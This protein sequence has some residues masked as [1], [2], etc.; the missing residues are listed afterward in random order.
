MP[1]TGIDLREGVGIMTV[2]LNTQKM[3]R[4]QPRDDSEFT[5]YTLPLTDLN[6]TNRGQE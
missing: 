5:G 4:A 6:S 2:N 3:K 1:T